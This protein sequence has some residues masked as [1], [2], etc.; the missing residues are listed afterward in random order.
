MQKK[1]RYARSR[2]RESIDMVQIV[3]YKIS[4]CE[5]ETLL[6]SRRDADANGLSWRIGQCQSSTTNVTIKIIRK[7]RELL[8]NSSSKCYTE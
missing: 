3:G 2:L 4:N 6:L 1:T 7:E 8:L 5:R